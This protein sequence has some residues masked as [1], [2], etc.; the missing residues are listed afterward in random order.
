MIGIRTRGSGIWAVV[1]LALFLICPLHP[2]CAEETVEKVK[3]DMPQAVISDYEFPGLEVEISLDI[4]DMDVVHFL[5]FLATEGNLNIVTSKSVA[6]PVNLL[7]NDVTIGD[8][9]EIV[10]SLNNL[11]YEVHGNVI[12]IISNDEYKALH[13]VNFYDERQTIVYQL[14]YA[15]PRTWARC[16]AMSKARSAK[17]SSTIRPE[18]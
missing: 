18:R 15:S 16:W 11:A 12:K 2:L 9:L 13:G 6:G 7:I 1:I 14:K 5:K 4:R 10:L 3:E 17:L 8:A